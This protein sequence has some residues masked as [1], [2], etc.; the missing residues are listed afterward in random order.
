MVIIKVLIGITKKV[1]GAMNLFQKLMLM[2]FVGGS[3]AVACDD[4]IAMAGYENQITAIK[5]FSTLSGTKIVISF[6][7]P[8]P[9]CTYHPGSF[10]ESLQKDVCRV[11]MPRTQLVCDVNNDASDDVD[12]SLDQQSS[13]E[14]VAANQDVE[15]LL[16]G[17]LVKKYV[18]KHSVIFVLQ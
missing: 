14:I 15:L 6:L 7:H 13:F 11:F 4:A 10:S 16:H 18:G 9:I 1:G 3:Y 8:N 2:M 5:E 12:Q 17:I